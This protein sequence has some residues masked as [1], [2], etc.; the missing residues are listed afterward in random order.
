MS[1]NA[2]LNNMDMSTKAIQ[3]R[4]RH[5]FIANFRH[6]IYTA[7]QKSIISFFSTVFFL[8]FFKTLTLIK[9]SFGNAFLY[10]LFWW[11]FWFI[12]RCVFAYRMEKKRSKHADIKNIA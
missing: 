11:M 9:V 1:K 2:D 7:A 4:K 10:P 5:A 6:A 3:N 8:L 12:V